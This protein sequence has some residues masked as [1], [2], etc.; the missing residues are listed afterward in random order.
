MTLLVI[1]PHG[2]ACLEWKEERSG[3]EDNSRPKEP[4]A[5]RYAGARLL[6]NAGE[7]GE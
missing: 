3:R 5:F 7:M 6:S 4:F 1:S 2:I